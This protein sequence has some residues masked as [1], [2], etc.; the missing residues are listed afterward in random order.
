MRPEEE[1]ACLLL[2]VGTRVL[3]TFQM[4]RPKTRMPKTRMDFHSPARR[5]HG[6]ARPPSERTGDCVQDAPIGPSTTRHG[7]AAKRI[8]T[9]VPV[10]HGN[11]EG[12]S[13]SMIVEL[14]SLVAGE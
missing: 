13:V 4:A 2:L 8:F 12:G 9:L 6:T 7:T 1:H 14:L 10:P 11:T 5:P 3:T